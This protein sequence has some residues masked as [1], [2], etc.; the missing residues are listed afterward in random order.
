MVDSDRSGMPVWVPD[1]RTVEDA[2][3]SVLM[4][5]HD[6]ATYD[7]LHT[8]SVANPDQ[9]WESVI[10]ELGISFVERP[11]S[12][13]GSTDPQNPHW[14]PGARL[15]I[16]AS[17]LS[18]DP[19]SV[20]IVEGHAGGRRSTTVGELT[21]RVAGF[22]AGFS[23]A[24]MMPGE[25]VAI[26]MPMTTEAV[27]AYLG[28]IAAGGIVV[29][30]ADSF[31]P[32]EIRSQLRVSQAVAVVTQD[33]A[34]RLGRTLPMYAKCIEAGAPQCIVVGRSP[35]R[36]GDVS[37]DDF[38]ATEAAFEPFVGS[39]SDTTNILFSS[40]T[41]GEPKAI[42]W[43]HTTSIKAAM[44]GRY[45]QDIRRGDVV[46][47]P[48]NL[49]WMMGPW[50]IYASLLNGATIALYAD[51]PT[52]RGFIEFVEAAGVTM[53][54]VVPSIV[55]TW[56]ADGALGAGEWTSVRVISSTGEASNASD[57]T[58]LTEMAGGVPIVEYCG[59]TELGGAYVTSTVL[60][61]SYPSRFNAAALGVDIHLVGEDGL[62][63]EYGEVFLSV[64]SIGFSTN[65]LNRDHAEVYFADVPD[66]GVPIRR[67][68]DLM[69]R[70][71][72]G[73]YQA[74]GRVDDTMNL[75]GVKVS[76]A[77]LERVLESVQGVREVAAVA[78]QPD[79]GGPD[80]LVVFV[81]SDGAAPDSSE[82]RGELQTAIA[83]DINPLFRIADVVLV[84][85]LPRTASQ[86]VMRRA[87]R[88]GYRQ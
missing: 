60:R 12:I 14:L 8:W 75:G 44:D 43:T 51:A 16:A 28:T 18:G 13:R 53:V 27:V 21:A 1:K 10:E 29:S 35:L 65:L 2:N 5:K 31:A 22:A 19:D 33:T 47:W 32:D 7:D 17:C 34:V 15:N 37:W 24:G 69:A 23:A 87:L 82:L 86:K 52:S 84:D 76:S 30:I 85:A 41:T 4:R 50:L 68:G 83:T 45:H 63:G 78:L 42:P 73:C 80:Q 26:I 77:E 48:T 54:G 40:G 49:G 74:L 67:H 62:E 56:R 61:P 57:Y 59:G 9:F 71:A 6:K 58:W 25:A 88:A 36:N 81:V 72:S 38:I 46:S 70:D 20:A 3:L 11:A 64:P 39:P 55:A 66:I 79:G